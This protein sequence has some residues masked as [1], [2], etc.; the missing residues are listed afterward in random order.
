MFMQCIQSLSSIRLY[1]Q[2]QPTTQQSLNTS[3]S[4]IADELHVILAQ[5]S[6]GL[7]VKAHILFVL[8]YMG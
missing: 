7:S 3:S 6:R 2:A 1:T 5:A 4:A 8:F